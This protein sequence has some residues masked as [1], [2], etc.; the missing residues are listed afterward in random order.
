MFA[1][2]TALSARWRSPGCHLADAWEIGPLVRGHNYSEGMPGRPV[3]VQGGGIGSTFR[4]RPGPC[5]RDDERDRTPFR[6]RQITMRFR[7]DAAP[8]TRF[9]AEEHP[10]FAPTVSLYIQRRGDNWSARGA[11]AS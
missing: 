5:R 9:I 10:E 7:I 6:C 3:P 8:G 4:A 2:A 11:Y 1:V